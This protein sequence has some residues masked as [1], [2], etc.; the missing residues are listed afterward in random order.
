M[1][2]PVLEIIKKWKAEQVAEKL[3]L[4]E[5]WIDKEDAVF[6][7]HMGSRLKPDTVSTQFPKWIEK[8]G[9]PRT[10]FH[11]LRHT[12]ASLLIEYGASVAEVSQMLGHSTI[13][14]TMN[15]YVH[16]FDDASKNMASKMN[17][18]LFEKTK[19]STKKPRK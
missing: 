19:K 18:I 2:K 12:A 17:A 13:G 9:L 5:K 1:P 16:A 11:E 10:T 7:T 3:F 8:M 4:G 15:I 14:T 6:T